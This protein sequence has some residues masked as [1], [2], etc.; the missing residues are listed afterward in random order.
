M[1]R[2]LRNYPLPTVLAFLLIVLFVLFV[3][4]ILLK[5]DKVFP[6]DRIYNLKRDG[7]SIYHQVLNQGE[8]KMLREQCQQGNYQQV[9]D[10]LLHHD[11]MKTVVKL[12]L[13]SQYR[14]Q[15]YIWIIQKSAVH[16]C[17]RDNNGHFFNQGQRW[18]SY[19][20]LVYF[21]D[22]DKC[23][24]VIPESHRE[25]GSYFINFNDSL[26]NLLCKQ[27][28][29]ILFDANLIH[30]GTI[31]DRDDNL[32]I[33]LKVSH[34]DDIPLL[35]YYNNFHKVLDEDNQLPKYLRKMQ[36]NLSCTFPGISDMGQKI[37]IDSARGSDNGA[38]VGPVQKAFSYLFYGKSNFYDLPNAY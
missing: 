32:R 4:N 20:M 2:T 7:F 11:R 22:M 12:A 26:T 8:T 6:I 3:L 38:T 14:F 31:N 5:T 34:V 27:G 13:G 10:Y 16:T 29:V 35:D 1:L 25:P 24:G 17:H 19:T 23:L 28:D 33:Q 21:E 30:V 37:N 15:D 18:P 9:Q 36:R